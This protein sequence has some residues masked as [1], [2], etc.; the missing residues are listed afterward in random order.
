MLKGKGK[1]NAERDLKSEEKM[2]GEKK[3]RELVHEKQEEKKRKRLE[4]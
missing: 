4:S 2:K 3:E 1:N